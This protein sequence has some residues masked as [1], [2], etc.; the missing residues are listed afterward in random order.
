MQD[1]TD[2][3]ELQIAQLE[4]ENRVLR[5]HQ[6][7]LE[8]LLDNLNLSI[9]AKEYATTDGT[10]IFANR[11]FAAAC[12]LN[13]DAVLHKRDRDLFDADLAA[14]YRQTDQAVLSAGQ[15]IEVEQV[16]PHPQ[17]HQTRLVSKFPIVTG[18][19]NSAIVCGV[20]EEGGDHPADIMPVKIP[21]KNQVQSTQK[22][23]QILSERVAIES[24]LQ[25]TQAFL[26]SVIGAMP[27]P[28]FVKDAASLRYV[29]WN[30]AAE[31]WFGMPAEEILG[32]T[33][34]DLFLP[35]Q[36]D[37]FTQR[38]LQVLDQGGALEIP[39]DLIR[40]R[41]GETR[42]LR[43]KIIPV[44]GS[45]FR[46]Q[47]HPQYL[48]TIWEDITEHKRA[49]T[50]LQQQLQLSRLRSQI[51]SALTCSSHSLREM[52]QRCSDAIVEHVDA[53]FARIW[54]FDSD[55]NQLVLQSSSGMYTHIDGPHARVPVGKFKIGLIAA[56]RKPHLT[57]SVFTDPR[58]GDPE[59][60]RREGLEAFAGYPLV[61]GDQ[62]LGV[63]ALFAR[64]ALN[65]STLDALSFISQEIALGIQRKHAELALQRSEAQ[66]RQ[67]TQFLEQTLQDLQQAQSQ[68]IQSEKMSGLGQLVAGVAHEINNPV[69]FIYG[70]LKHAKGY[71]QALL[72]LIQ[73]YQI[74]CPQRSQA[75][76]AYEQEIDLEFLRTD[77]PQ[78]LQSMQVGTDRIREIVLSLRTFSRLDEA[79]YKA[80]NLHE[81]LD[82]TLMI[83]QHRL[84]PKHGKSAVTLI[85]EYGNLPLVECYSGQLNQVFMNVLVNAI[86]ALETR[87]LINFTL[88]EIR[89]RTAVVSPDRVQI[90]VTDNGPGM[91][92]EIQQR[93]F[94]PFF[95][96]KP[97]GMGT[98]MG[99][100]ISYQIVVDRHNGSLRCVS[101][102]GQGAS[103]IIEIPLMQTPDAE[104]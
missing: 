80:T 92:P 71:S 19:G 96:T 53:A 103:F 7:L 60:A 44:G 97:V 31:A 61:V 38:D 28:V 13:R 100:S 76:A 56:E 9:F 21:V 27:M 30:A 49:E 65:S 3:L 8:G 62:L 6:D 43:I 69:N 55:A 1:K 40:T 90:Q 85:K 45:E 51:D 67:Q 89:I 48:L 99:L 35:E 26:T 64:H 88:P 25:Q 50:L 86:D 79:E 91:T 77:L 18:E 63:V 15:P 94:D 84:K 52:L 95:T 82:S 57:N 12:H 101:A 81:G 39:E 5:Q 42:I 46:P 72:H 32:R 98:G 75:I 29:L 47:H 83:L 68:L 36:A 2:R 14:T 102:P 11:Q 66:L 59:W 33:D 16:V 4:Q 23:S 24:E 70:N 20:M 87:D 78:L 54:T 37:L 104:T 93:L 10:Y 17:G 58:V 22:P 41:Q 34:A 73:L 74:H